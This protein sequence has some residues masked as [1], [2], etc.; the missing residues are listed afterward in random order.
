M[1]VRTYLLLHY[2]VLPKYLTAEPPEEATRSAV[3]VV[4][5]GTGMHDPS[6]GVSPSTS[7]GWVPPVHGWSLVKT[8]KRNCRGTLLKGVVLEAVKK[9]STWKAAAYHPVIL[10]VV[11]VRTHVVCMQRRG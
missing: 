3:Y 5:K 10:L 4:P 9:S 1:Y 8:R 7:E 6:G 11:H 2:M